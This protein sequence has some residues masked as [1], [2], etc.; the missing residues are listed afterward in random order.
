[1]A[2]GLKEKGLDLLVEIVKTAV[3]CQFLFEGNIFSSINKGIANNT[4]M[5]IAN[6]K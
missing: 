4:S 6:C 2:S 3:I 5:I 1:M